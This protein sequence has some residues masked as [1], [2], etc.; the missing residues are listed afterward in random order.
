MLDEVLEVAGDTPIGRE[1]L[2]GLKVT[3][4]VLKESMRVYPPVP[5]L[6]RIAKKDME[7]GGTKIA[8]GSLIFIPIYAVHR[9]HHLWEDPDRFDPKRFAPERESA[10]SPYQ[11]LPF[12]AGPRI[13]I[14]SSFAMIEL[15]VILAALL[16][17]ETTQALGI[18]F[19]SSST[20]KD[21][22]TTTSSALSAFIGSDSAHRLCLFATNPQS[23]GL[24]MHLL[25]YA[26][27]PRSHHQ[28]SSFMAAITVLTAIERSGSGGIGN[29]RRFTNHKSVRSVFRPRT[30]SRMMRPFM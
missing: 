28:S 30:R 24:C 11:Y 1:H 18:I 6:T 17:A 25:S 26:S 2:D 22:W 21:V 10:Y 12:G 8:A 13:C 14:G 15:I 16:N 20:P 27:P 23:L 5:T 7:L 4:M 3:T 19:A 9:H 29:D